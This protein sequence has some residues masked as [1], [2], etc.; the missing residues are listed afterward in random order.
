M[1]LRNGKKILQNVND[2]KI[3]NILI[4]SNEIPSN[5]KYIANF[6][7][8]IIETHNNFKPLH[9]SC[10]SSRINLFIEEVRLLRELYYLIDYYGLHKKQNPKFEKFQLSLKQKTPEFIDSIRYQLQKGILSY[11]ILSEFDLKNVNELLY[12]MNTMVLYFTDNKSK[13]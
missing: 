5:E 12:E 4:P 1:Q 7:Q 2:T 10:I 9:S 6:I 13:N 11:V 3:D 8:K